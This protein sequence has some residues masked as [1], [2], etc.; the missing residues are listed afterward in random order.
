MAVLT[1]TPGFDGNWITRFTGQYRG[2]CYDHSGAF[3][4]GLPVEG[5][6]VP[7][8]DGDLRMVR[9]VKT[10]GIMTRYG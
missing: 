5:D 4:T 3:S 9:P 2:R 7:L 1:D 10:A 8:S 6:G